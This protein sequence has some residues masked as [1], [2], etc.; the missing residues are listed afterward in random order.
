MVN[1][2]STQGT[3]KMGGGAALTL[4]ARA[5]EPRRAELAVGALE[6]GFAHTASHP[7]VL[8]A[9]VALSPC[10]AA[11]TVCKKGEGVAQTL[12]RPVSSLPGKPVFCFLFSHFFQKVLSLVCIN[13]TQ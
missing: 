6:V 11:V 4:T 13:C 3:L 2:W 10:S 9:G 1:A 5:I 12:C 7:R 8:P